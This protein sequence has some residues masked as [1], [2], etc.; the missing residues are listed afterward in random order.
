MKISSKMF[1]YLAI[2]GA[3]VMSA[4][5]ADD[6]QTMCSQTCSQAAYSASESAK[7][8]IAQQMAQSCSQISDPAGQSQCYAAIPTTVNQQGQQVYSSVYNSC[9]GACMY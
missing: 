1:K 2:A 3:I 7:Q 6:R 8:S 9:M 5:Y 4:A